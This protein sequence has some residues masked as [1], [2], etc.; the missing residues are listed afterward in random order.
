M[1]RYVVCFSRS[2]RYSGNGDLTYEEAK[3]HFT[4]WALMK[5]PLLI[6][7][8]VSILLFFWCVCQANSNILATHG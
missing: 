3:T 1:L 4:A 6:S 8:H 2:V 7:A 5:S